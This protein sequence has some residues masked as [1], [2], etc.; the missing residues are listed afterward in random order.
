MRFIGDIHGKVPPYLDLI[1]DCEESVQVGDFGMGFIGTYNRGR[2]DDMQRWGD[3][4][5]IRGNHDDPAICRE[6][7]GW[8]EDGTYDK[9]R[10]MM[11]IGGAWS[12]DHEYRK[13]TDSQN[14]TVS[15]WP[16]EELAVSEL[17]KIHA[18]FVYHK[19]KIV[20]THDCPMRVSKELFFNGKYRMLGP[21]Q[22]T[23]TAEALQ[24]MFMEHQP[25]LWIFGHWHHSERKKIDGTEFICLAELEHIDISV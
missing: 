8:I 9:D 14:G 15:W 12:I 25:D 7:L 10:E 3:H 4:R 22:S 13:R 23:R 6:S 19:P 20:I 5:F 18:N 1:A 24:A 16:D 2:V 21:H 11:F 17:A